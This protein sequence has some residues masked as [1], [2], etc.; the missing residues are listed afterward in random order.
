MY[1]T[2][3]KTFGPPLLETIYFYFVQKYDKFIYLVWC[4]PFNDKGG[5]RKILK[6]RNKNLDSTIVG[7]HLLQGYLVLGHKEPW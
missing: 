4:Q 5:V 2:Q 3:R 6:S 1:H 7:G